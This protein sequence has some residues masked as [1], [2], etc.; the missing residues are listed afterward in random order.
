MF[1]I[2]ISIYKNILSKWIF[3]VNKK[4]KKQFIQAAKQFEHVQNK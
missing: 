1:S 2:Q 3:F 4:K